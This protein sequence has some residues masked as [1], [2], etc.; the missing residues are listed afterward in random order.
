MEKERSQFSEQ[1]ATQQLVK[2]E[3]ALHKLEQQFLIPNF[4]QLMLLVRAK[5]ETDFKLVLSTILERASYSGEI[6]SFMNMLNDLIKHFHPESLILKRNTPFK[7]P[8]KELVSNTNFTSEEW[9]FIFKLHTNI[10]TYMTFDILLNQATVLIGS[11]ADKGKD[12]GERMTP[13]E[14]YTRWQLRV[15]GANRGEA[16]ELLTAA[17]ERIN[18]AEEAAQSVDHDVEAQVAFNTSFI[19]KPLS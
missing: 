17:R 19:T 18:Q 10:N 8:L 2:T 1:S 7:H 16:E 5:N 4:E 14:E 9:R 12:P 3:Q 6:D 13:Q 15:M 11:M